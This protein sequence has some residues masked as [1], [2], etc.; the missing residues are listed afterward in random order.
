MNS[1]ENYDVLYVRNNT[2][3]DYS[4]ESS[5]PFEVV[6]EG[7]GGVAED[8]DAVIVDHVQDLAQVIL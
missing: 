7:P 6:H 2:I 8:I 4:R 3:E 1:N 5:P